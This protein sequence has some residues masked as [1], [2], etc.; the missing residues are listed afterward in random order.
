MSHVIRTVREWRIGCDMEDR[1]TIEEN[2]EEWYE[3]WGESL[4]HALRL[5]DD[6]KALK[7]FAWRV[8]VNASMP[9]DAAILLAGHLNYDRP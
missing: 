8:W 3:E 6:P 1:D 4:S 5:Q 2:F 7:A 9:I